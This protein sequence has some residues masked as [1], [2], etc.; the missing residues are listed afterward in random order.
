[1]LEALRNTI[2]CARRA[3]PNTQ[4]QYSLAVQEPCRASL[5]EKLFEELKT[6]TYKIILES[7][8]E[9]LGEIGITKEHPEYYSKLEA[10][11]NSMEHPDANFEIQTKGILLSLV[12]KEK[13][14]STSVTEKPS[15]A[16]SVEPKG[17]GHSI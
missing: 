16:K 1:M 9:G 7:L 11:I 14:I 2:G 10:K 4:V 12:Q 17:Q 8:K 5:G 15:W 3:V 6:S 13:E